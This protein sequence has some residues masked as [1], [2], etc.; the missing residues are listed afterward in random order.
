M[1]VPLLQ[2][3]AAASLQKNASCVMV[4]S[5]IDGGSGLSREVHS[6]DLM[7]EEGTNRAPHTLS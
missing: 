7:K 4:S 3:A 6:V 5:T 1:L 2:P